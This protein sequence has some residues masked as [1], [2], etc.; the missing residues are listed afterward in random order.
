MI[1]VDAPA[2]AGFSYATTA[3]GYYSDDITASRHIYEF[4]K[5]VRKAIIWIQYAQ[6]CYMNVW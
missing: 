6:V 3:E 1:F 5:K 4:L 2:G